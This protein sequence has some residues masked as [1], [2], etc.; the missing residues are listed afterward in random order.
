MEQVDQQPVNTMSNHI[1]TNV[2]GSLKNGVMDTLKSITTLTT[3]PENGQ[4]EMISKLGDM[5]SFLVGIVLCL[6]FSVACWSFG[7]EPLLPEYPTRADHLKLWLCFCFPAV[8]IVIVLMG[9]K[10]V[11]SANG[12]W[13]QYLFCTGAILLPV[14][15]GIV[16][17][18]II[19]FI[20]IELVA[21]ISLLTVTTTILVLHL[22]LTKVVNMSVRATMLL[23]PTILV[24]IGYVMKVLYFSFMI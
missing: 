17:V 19:G 13:K 8:A 3:N 5:R 14:T 22:T 2:I 21:F 16:T 4:N 6:G 10:Q 7:N 23:I 12:N 15:L 11:F 20:N 24:L 9:I 18:N 1:V